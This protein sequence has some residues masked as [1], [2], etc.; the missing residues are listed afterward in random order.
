MLLEQGGWGLF[1]TMVKVPNLGMRHDQAAKLPPGAER[2]DLLKGARQAETALKIE[3]W[4]NSGSATAK[5][6]PAESPARRPCLRR[7]H[8]LRSELLMRH[9]SDACAWVAQFVAT[10]WIG[11][12]ALRRMIPRWHPSSALA[13]KLIGA[14]LTGWFSQP[15]DAE[16]IHKLSGVFISCLICSSLSCRSASC[17]KRSSWPSGFPVC[18]HN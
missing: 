6:A 17:Q 1:P 10:R 4:A 12:R 8:L 7:G 2:D 16:T 9:P 5:I 11:G 14:R 3:E 15:T 18:S 13:C